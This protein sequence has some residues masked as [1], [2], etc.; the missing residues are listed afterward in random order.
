MLIGS[1]LSASLSLAP[2]LLFL[3]ILPPED[4]TAKNPNTY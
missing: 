4:C 2:S 1:L 3:L